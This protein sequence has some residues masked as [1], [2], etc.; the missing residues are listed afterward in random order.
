MGLRVV[1]VVLI[2]WLAFAGTIVT[3][4]V[5]VEAEI[6]ALGR[7]LEISPAVM[8]NRLP[9]YG[10]TCLV[11]LAALCVG[12]IAFLKVLWSRSVWATIL[13]SLGVGLTTPL[14]L[15]QQ[16][17]FIADEVAPGVIHA[18]LASYLTV[19]GGPFLIVTALLRTG[20][21]WVLPSGSA[22]L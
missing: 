16:I 3:A 14:L 12:L 18:S 22:S 2:A 7:V 21:P 8:R 10:A 1:I 20:F 19:L 5:Q 4:I 17:V 13:L 11:A 9:G 6:G 15:V